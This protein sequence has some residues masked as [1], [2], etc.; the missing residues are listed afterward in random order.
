MDSQTVSRET[1]AHTKG[2]RFE[3]KRPQDSNV[4]RGEGPLDA[5]SVNRAEYSAKV[6]DRSP[7]RRPGTSD[8]WKARLHSLYQPRRAFRTKA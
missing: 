5:Q 7:G 3:A 1:Y 2:E 6:A 4:L 8:V